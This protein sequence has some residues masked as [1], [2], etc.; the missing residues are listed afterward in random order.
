VIGRN[1]QGTAVKEAA[2]IVVPQ[3]PA[4]PID[5]SNYTPDQIAEQLIMSEHEIFVRRSRC[6]DVCLLTALIVTSFLEPPT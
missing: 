5:L 2:A 3:K 6:V 1:E 4:V